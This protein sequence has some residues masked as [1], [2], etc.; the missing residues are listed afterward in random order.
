MHLAYYGFVDGTTSNQVI[1]QYVTLIRTG[2]A[3]F[4]DMHQ[5]LHY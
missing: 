3:L 5:Y 2:K 4:E 1:D